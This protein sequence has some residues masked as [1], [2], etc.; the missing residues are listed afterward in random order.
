MRCGDARE[1]LGVQRDGDLAPSEAQAL[2]EHLKK[3]S[4]CRAFEQ[5]LQQIHFILHVSTSHAQPNVSTDKIML[6]IQQ[7]KRITQ[8]LEDI[9][10]QQQSRLERLSPIGAACTALG[11][12]TLSS[13]PLLLLAMA[14]I[15]T[16]L[17]VK[18]LYL[19]NGVIDLFIILAQYIQVEQAMIEHN[20]WLLSAMA[21]AVVVMMGMWLRLMR[22]PQEA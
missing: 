2:E 6:A 16:D 1:K 5:S 9:H 3:C 7:R 4:S 12:F 10:Q 8:Q 14:I 13:I 11:I 20:S 21:F 19:F 18:V 22:R 15:Q 17:A